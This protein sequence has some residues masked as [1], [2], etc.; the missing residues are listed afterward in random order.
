MMLTTCFVVYTCHNF[1]RPLAVP[2]PQAYVE[3]FVSPANFKLLEAAFPRYRSLTYHAVNQ[4][5]EQVRNIDTVTAVT[6]GIFRGRE[7][8]Q[9]TVVDPESF[10]TV[11]KKEAFALWQTQWSSVCA[12]TPTRLPQS[13]IDIHAR[14]W[15]ECLPPPPCPSAEIAALMLLPLSVCVAVS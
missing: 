13:T 7:I 2:R 1:N 11:W 5:G 4:S 8:L 15:V 6:W 9:P 3:F 10:M 14:P 12:P